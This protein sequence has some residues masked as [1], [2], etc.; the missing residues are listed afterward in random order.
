MSEQ[1]SKES[2]ILDYEHEI[3]T[4]EKWKAEGILMINASTAGEELADER[5]QVPIDEYIEDLK[6]WKLLLERGDV[7][8][9][10]AN[11]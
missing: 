9:E 7:S 8:V 11:Y 4:A 10:Q 1:L 2:L 6:N 5:E 3:K